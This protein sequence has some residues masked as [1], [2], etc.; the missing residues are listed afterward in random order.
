MLREP[1][2][3]ILSGSDSDELITLGQGEGVARGK[4]KRLSA[5]NRQDVNRCAVKKGGCKGKV[6]VL[7]GCAAGQGSGSGR[8]LFE[9]H[10]PLKDWTIEGDTLQKSCRRSSLG[11][12]V[13]VVPVTPARCQECEKRESDRRVSAEKEGF[14]RFVHKRLQIIDV[15]RF[16]ESDLCFP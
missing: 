6:S 3:K 8:V 16:G 9:G 13:E 15:K 11:R 2:E 5:G 12:K 10:R 4:I 7:V 14:Q 1:L